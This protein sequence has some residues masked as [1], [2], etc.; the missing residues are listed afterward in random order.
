MYIFRALQ[1]EPWF[2]PLAL[3]A[4]AQLSRESGV[5]ASAYTELYAA[6]T[7]AGHSDLPEAVASALFYGPSAL[8]KVAAQP[9]HGVL[10]GAQH[11]LTH[12]LSLVRHDWQT[13][14]ADI[15]KEDVPPLEALAPLQEG[16]VALLRE[17]LCSGTVA[18]VLDALLTAYRTNGTGDMARFPAFRWVGGTLQGVTQPAW[19]DVSRLVGL[20][21]PLSRL[22]LN[23]EAFLRGEPAQHTLLYGPRGSG[24]STAVRSLGGRYAADGLRF[25]EVTPEHLAELPDIL[26]RLRGGPHRYLLFVDDLAFGSDSGTYGPLKSLLEGSLSGRPDNVRVYATSNRR[27]L[28]SERF[29]DRPDPLN[30]DPLA[31]DTQHERLALSDRFGLVITFPDATQRKYLAIVRSLAAQDG[32]V[33]DD[34]EQKAVRFADWGNG[35]SGRTAQQFV[36]ALRSGLA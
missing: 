21:G 5:V 22:H 33:D 16:A 9:P 11:D 8:A 6:L 18:E 17:R 12:L 13:V 20:E 32:L 35:Y 29:S 14:V 3:L 31:W 19:T 7:E 25:V 27:H 26:G 30:D 23:T 15:L 4:G 2:G 36:E 10:E 34:L 24:K 28:V 1:D